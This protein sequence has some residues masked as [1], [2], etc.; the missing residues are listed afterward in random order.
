MPLIAFTGQPLR[1]Y[2]RCPV[3]AYGLQQ[4]EQIE[5]DALLQG[6]IALNLH[7][8]MLPEPA[9]IFLLLSG[10]SA[11]SAGLGHAVHSGAPLPQFIFTI[12]LRG[13]I[14]DILGQN[15]SFPALHCCGVA[16][17]DTRADQL[18]AQFP[19]GRSPEA[20]AY[21]RQQR[22]P[23]MPRPLAHPQD[24]LCLLVTAVFRQQA[25]LGAA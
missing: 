7:V 23:C 24:S 17:R 4:L 8:R 22:K 2:V 5:A 14:G 16:D 12:I 15:N 9:E 1:G 3:P 21:G 19:A 6:G 13:V 25:R 11:E 10:Q 20:V 18:P